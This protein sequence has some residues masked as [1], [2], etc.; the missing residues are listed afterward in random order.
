MVAPPA[1]TICRSTIPLHQ[2]GD[3]RRALLRVAL[4]TDMLFI[5]LVDVGAALS[6]RSYASEEPLVLDVTDAFMPENAGPLADR[7]RRRRRQRRTTLTSM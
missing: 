7:R 5:R 3:P 2:L 6:A 4:H 1:P